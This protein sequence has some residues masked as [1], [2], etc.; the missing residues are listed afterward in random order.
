M[1]RER[2][3]LDEE[4]DGARRSAHHQSA[5]QEKAP[6]APYSAVST[7]ARRHHYEDAVYG[8]D[9][10]IRRGYRDAFRSRHPR[11]RTSRMLGASVTVQRSR[12][13]FAPH[14]R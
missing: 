1:L 8:H 10:V 9:G 5:V 12:G 11:R 3:S 2:A 4:H 13:N 7:V 14:V 6:H